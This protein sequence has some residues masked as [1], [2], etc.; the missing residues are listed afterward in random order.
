MKGNRDTVPAALKSYRSKLSSY[1]A[2]EYLDK[3]NVKH[4]V[5]YQ[6]VWLLNQEGKISFMEQFDRDLK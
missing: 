6:Q 4:K 1:K 5:K 2:D 3:G